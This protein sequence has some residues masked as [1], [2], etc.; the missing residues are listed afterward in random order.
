MAANGDGTSETAG[1]SVENLWAR[2]GHSMRQPIQASLF[3]AHIIKTQTADDPQLSRTTVAL[4]DALQGLQHQL[5]LLSELTRVKRA[6]PQTIDLSEFS[7]KIVSRVQTLGAEQGIEILA[8]P[9]RGG[10]VSDEH[11]LR[12]AVTSLYVN[13]MRL[14]TE[15]PV[16]SGWRPRGVNIRFEVVFRAPPLSTLQ[17]DAAFVS[18]SNPATG[19]PIG[20]PKLGLGFIA[21]VCKLLGHSL[22]LSSPSLSVQKF[23]LELPRA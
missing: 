17:A 15:G 23:S 19:R 7:A 8:R 18:L 1:P 9:P 10:V 22:A 2:A 13:A 3:I 14:R 16:L 12:L 11:L 4:E 6:F 20:S 21:H 5:E